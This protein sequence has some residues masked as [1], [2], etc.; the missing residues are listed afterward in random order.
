[1][2]A[3][4]VNGPSATGTANKT[5]V[6]II[7]ATV[8][9]RVYEF[10]VGVKTDPNTTDQQLEGALQRFTA[11]GTAGSS[12]T[13]LPVDPGDTASVTT[14][15]ITHSA[16]PT[17]TATGV[18]MGMTMNQRAVFRW[19]AVPGMEFMAPATAA[20]GIG[21]KNVAITATAIINGNIQFQE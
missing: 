6:T 10:S 16:E 18:L 14:A 1:M 2:R 3:Y 11:A 7:G 17:Y 15:G 5:A 8:R 19:V 4:T 21:L 13:P 20:N 12:P 9:P